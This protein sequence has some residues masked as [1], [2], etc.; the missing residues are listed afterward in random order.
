MADFAIERSIG[1]EDAKLSTR[2]HILKDLK[3]VQV[4]NPDDM[5]NGIVHP[6]DFPSWSTIGNPRS[7]CWK[8]FVTRM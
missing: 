4:I 5:A 1:L 3:V 2:G 7:T 8:H 6:H